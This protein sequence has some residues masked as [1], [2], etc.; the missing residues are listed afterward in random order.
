MQLSMSALCQKQTYAGAAEMSDWQ[1]GY[2]LLHCTCP[3]MT[4]S[5]HSRRVDPPQGRDFKQSQNWF[6]FTR[7][8]CWYCCGM[9]F[10]AVMKLDSVSSGRLGNKGGLMSAQLHRGTLFGALIIVWSS[11][12]VWAQ[13]GSSEN[14]VPALLNCSALSSNPQKRPEFA[15]KVEMQIAKGLLTVERETKRRPGKERLTGSVAKDGTIKLE[16]NGEYQD[17]GDGW[18]T[19]LVGALNNKKEVVLRGSLRSG[20]GKGKGTRRCEL[21]FLV[22]PS[23]IRTRLSAMFELQQQQEVLEQRQAETEK[24]VEGVTTVLK[25]IILPVTETPGDWMLRVSAV[26]VQQQQFCRIVDRFYDDLAAVYLMRNE[27]RKNA[28]FRDRQ[29]DLAALLPSGKF[30]NWVVTIKEVKQTAD[31]GAAIML[32]PPCRAMLGSDICQIESSKMAT[33]IPA[34]SPMVREL[35]KVGA[36]DFIVISGKIL[37]AAEASANEPTPIRAIYQAGSH[38]S[39]IEGAKTEDVF[40]S[41]ITYLA[42]LK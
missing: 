16:G 6:L 31:G 39:T 30:E 27:L 26:P 11:Q 34:N 36:G 35:E 23:E 9:L 37:Y 18:H 12:F 15:S 8:L 41:Q 32:Q 22:P 33:A 20:Y 1:S 4:Q 5:G 29:K 17:G 13:T 38:C 25:D 28:L 7:I 10:R 14:R 40:V 42:R 3:L 24:K 2:A 19:V 21:T